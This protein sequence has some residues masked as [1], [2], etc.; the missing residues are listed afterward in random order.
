MAV[1]KGFHLCLKAR[2]LE[3]QL[4]EL[5]AVNPRIFDL[6]DLLKKCRIGIPVELLL[7]GAWKGTQE[8]RDLHRGLDI[9]FSGAQKIEDTQ[10]YEYGFMVPAK[11]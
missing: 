9:F 11:Y 5:L 6:S 4:A 2:F 10:W 1:Q 3:V 7:P 8:L